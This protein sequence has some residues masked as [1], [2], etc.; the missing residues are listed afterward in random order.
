VIRDFIPQGENLTKAEKAR[1][2]GQAAIRTG[3]GR[4]DYIPEEGN[5][6][7][8]P[9]S[10]SK[11]QAAEAL[12]RALDRQ[13]HFAAQEFALAQERLKAWNVAEAITAMRVMPLRVC[14]MYLVAEQQ[15][16]ARKSI[17]DQFPAPD[18]KVVEQ[19]TK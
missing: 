14:E 12:Q 7:P 15:A 2:K 16:G 5:E 4:Q 1:L 18:P 8:A 13:E 10:G 11:A 3:V 9:P 19:F 17:L 6:K